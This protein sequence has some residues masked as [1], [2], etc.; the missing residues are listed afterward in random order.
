M[1][2]FFVTFVLILSYLSNC[3]DNKI[4]F[5]S[6]PPIASMITITAQTIGQK[7]LSV[8]TVHDQ[9]KILSQASQGIYLQTPGK[10]IVYLSF[11]KYPGPLSIT[12]P[13]FK[14]YTRFSIKDDH[15]EIADQQIRFPNSDLSI[16][17]A[18]LSGWSPPAAEIDPFSEDEKTAH[19]QIQHRIASIAQIMQAAFP[20]HG[21]LFSDAI[22]NEPEHPPVKGMDLSILE[23]A[24]L[25]TSCILKHERWLELPDTFSYLL[26]LGEGLTPQGD[27]F[28]IGL[29]LAIHRWQALLQGAVP[30]KKV[31]QLTIENAYRSTTTISA[32]LLEC[33]AEGLADERL[34]QASDSLMTGIPNP[35]TAIEQIKTWGSTSGLSAW[36]GLAIGSLFIL[37]HRIQSF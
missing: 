29:F 25:E 19:S 31:S 18:D 9:A 27:D 30:W 26:G 4:H 6:E 37:D 33:A 3:L 10:W 24:I 22:L 20:D 5:S 32:N 14:S 8:I 36:L 15:I 16:S 1:Y 7:A 13:G 23:S 17:F 12:L 2:F 21:K 28:I 11:S 34:I 35:E